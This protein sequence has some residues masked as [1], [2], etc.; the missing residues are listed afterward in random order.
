[1][2][3]RATAS[4]PRSS[5]AARCWPSTSRPA[6]STVTSCRTGWWRFEAAALAPRLPPGQSPAVAGRQNPAGPIRISDAPHLWRAT[7][8]GEAREDQTAV[9]RALRFHRRVEEELV[10]HVLLR[11]AAAE[12]MHVS[13]HR[14]HQFDGTRIL[15]ASMR[16]HGLAD[17]QRD[18]ADD[19]S[20]GF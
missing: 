16:Q 10:E 5:S 1:M 12:A 18:I 4:S 2:A 8:V 20:N 15:T 7:L 19:R 11:V 14:A 3:A 6:R 9:V 17:G 13:E